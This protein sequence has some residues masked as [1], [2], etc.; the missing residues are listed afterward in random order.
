MVTGIVYSE[1]YL[2]HNPGLG[3]PERPER[4]KAIVEGLE[5]SGLWSSPN[6]RI[7]EP[8]PAT[9]GDIELAHDPDYVSLVEKLSAVEKSVD[10]D[11]PARKNTFQLALLAAGGAIEA[12]RLVMS[13]EARNAFAL[14]RPPG[15]HASRARGG[16][17]CYFNNVAVMIEHMKRD[18]KLR[19]IFVLDIDAHHGNGTQDIFNDDPSVLYMSIHQHPLTLYPGT[20]FADEIGTG[21]GRGY[22]V[23]APLDPGSGDAEYGAVMQE[24][25]TP[26]CEQFKPEL[27]AVSAGFDAHADDPLTN[28][29]LTTTAYGWLASLVIDQARKLCGGRVVFLLEGGYD[30]KALSGGVVNI[31]KAMT[32]EKFHPPTELRRPKIIDEIKQTLAGKWK[33]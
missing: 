2:E 27:F 33:L 12:G 19:R 21:E 30:P 3:H 16:G 26:L 29:Q 32:G 6:V 14:V 25:F 18:F 7:I 10:G 31:V 24:I 23:N 20:G 22:K 8:N 17:F 4:L 28:L 9:S 5:K 13:G 15:H 11:T 1:K